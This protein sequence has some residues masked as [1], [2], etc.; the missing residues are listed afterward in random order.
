MLRNEVTHLPAYN[1]RYYD[2]IFENEFDSRIRITGESILT[3][4]TDFIDGWCGFSKLAF[5][6]VDSCGGLH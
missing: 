4:E 1:H 5:E 3:V 2:V 6:L